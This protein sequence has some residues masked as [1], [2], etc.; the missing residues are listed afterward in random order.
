MAEPSP[1]SP[2]TIVGPYEVLD[3]LGKGGMGV[4]FRA[5]HRESGE[6]AALKTVR[7]PSPMLLSSIR[8]EI[9][10]LRRLSHPGVVR[11][12]D[13]GVHDS[14]PWYTMELFECA[15]WE[16]QLARRSSDQRPTPSE[17]LA[18]TGVM[19]TALGATDGP[20]VIITVQDRLPLEEPELREVLAR[21][22]WLCE[23]LTYIHGEGVVH[24]DLKPGNVFLPGSH[25]TVLVDFGLVV[26]YSGPDGREVMQVAPST[27]GTVAYMAPEQ[28]DGELVDARADIF[29]LGCMLYETLTGKLPFPASFRERLHLHRHPL[30]P[31]SQ[32]L[33]W[34]PRI[35]DELLPKMLAPNR[36]ERLGH[37][38]DLSA[39]LASSLFIGLPTNETPQWT[40]R[41]YL[42][43]A[44]FAGRDGLLDT[45]LSRLHALGEGHGELLLLEGESGS[46]KTRLLTEFLRRASL[47][48]AFV[49]AG[50]CP[51]QG[52]STQGEAMLHAGPLT[53]LRP[54]LQAV[55]DLCRAQGE[56]TTLTL[57]HHHLPVLVLIEP[58][59]AEVPGAEQFSEAQ[60]L[61]IEAAKHR[62]LNAV[63]ELLMALA[64]RGPLVLLLDDLQWADELTMDVLAH[65][66]STLL[67][68][69]PVLIIGSYRTEETMPTLE[70]LAQRAGVTRLALGR[71]DEQAVGSL[72][73]DML[74]VQAAPAELVR[75]VAE[76][77]AGNPF[78]I[79]E[80]LQTAVGER[81]LHRNRQG[82]WVVSDAASAEGA[83][84]WLA[85]LQ[86]LGLPRTLRAIVERRLQRLDK[87][88]ASVVLAAAVLG[89]EFDAELLRSMSDLSERELAD[90]LNDLLRQRF[91]DPAGGGRYRF[92]HDKLR[93]AAYDSIPKPR[94]LELHR[95][96]AY[97]I[98][99]RGAHAADV[100]GLANHFVKG[101]V[102]SKARTYLLSAAQQ[103]LTTGAHKQAAPLLVQA[104][105]FADLAGHLA[106]PE[107]R[108]NLHRLYA[109]ALF[110][111][112]ETHKSA[113]QA[114]RALELF[115][116]GVPDKP[117]RIFVSFV[118]QLVE[119]VYRMSSE[120]RLLR[121]VDAEARAVAAA[122]AALR[123]CT[124][125][126]TDTRPQL[127]VMMATLLAANLA[128]RA[129]PLGPRAV[130]YGTLGCTAGFLRMDGVARRYFERARADAR[131]R[132]DDSG[133]AGAAILECALYQGTAQWSAL[134]AC[135][136]AAV[137]TSERCG[138][139]LSA[140]GLHLVLGGG[141]L[142]M[143]NLSAAWLL[144]SR[145]RSSACLRGADLNVGWASVLL[146][147]HELWRSEPVRARELALAAMRNFASDRGT[148]GANALAVSAASALLLGDRKQA[149]QH[150]QEASAMLSR[151]PVLF[152]MWPA[153][154]LLPDSLLQLW[155][156]AR[157]ARSSDESMLHKLAKQAC[158][159]ARSMAMAAPIGAPLSLRAMGVLARIEGKPQRAKKQLEEA[160]TRAKQLQMPVAEA[161]IYVELAQT[162]PVYSEKRQILAQ[163]AEQAA[164]AVSCQHWVD[165]A[166]ALIHRRHP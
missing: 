104:L 138:D 5:R 23:T 120:R 31:P 137:A 16:Q 158:A 91:F 10:R 144:L 36:R 29:A 136:K 95:A 148:A 83:R 58:A 132:G 63:S 82:D 141:S 146:A 100:L 121:G 88:L 119:Q 49:A 43:R 116:V 110:G 107:E 161:A 128:D 4:V 127:Q 15:T 129:G 105:E 71:L 153:C 135:H 72:I 74:A 163:R 77:A 93:E 25:Q 14:L 67:S 166:R 8:R 2:G 115:G 45:L 22:R 68:T 106:A 101:V 46:G 73:S 17:Q 157:A 150:A 155:Q 78:F 96:A 38:S 50:E 89:R 114:E 165:R 20:D 32:F 133:E 81:L 6:L 98:E 130:S 42:Y 85:R 131:A 51:P 66:H 64:R 151:G 13:D 102:P 28:L 140:E 76:Q 52:V 69:Q 19:A 11:I 124:C 109:D 12:R 7:M 65:L 156:A 47:T 147:L 48:G 60:P 3:T 92:G 1:F 125:Y 87:T 122:Q 55:A 30:T 152:Q 99:A 160:L 35:L 159:Q 90:A 117:W 33:P 94:L 111:M 56:Q 97:A 61:P 75:F 26:A 108:A 123:L 34:L 134:V 40:A 103:L 126:F 54:L 44:S 143:G 154:D 145:V 70:Q 80:Y 79:T 9:Q 41:D 24:R 62:L 39:A 27:A 86:S 162:A 18:A 57:L 139:V 142:L 53:P 112:G 37:A 113:A 149:Q 164:L 21:T 59:L 118:R 84:S